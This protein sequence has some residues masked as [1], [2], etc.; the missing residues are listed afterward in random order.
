MIVILWKN[1]YSY[2]RHT[3]TEQLSL[4]RRLLLLL[5]G[6]IGI[7]RD[8]QTYTVE[9]QIFSYLYSFSFKAMSSLRNY[10]FSQIKTH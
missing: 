8:F 6:I 2:K 4:G 3:H 1:T 9:L 10:K 5:I 7:S